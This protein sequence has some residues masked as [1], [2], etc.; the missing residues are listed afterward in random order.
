MFFGEQVGE[1]SG[2]VLT[3]SAVTIDASG[4]ILDLFLKYLSFNKLCTSVKYLHKNVLYT[5]DNACDS[6]IQNV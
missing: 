5:C 1:V 2:Q 6:K 4:H 3:N